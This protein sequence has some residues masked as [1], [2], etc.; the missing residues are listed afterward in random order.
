[1][2][3]ALTV[4]DWMTMVQLIYRLNCIEDFLQYQSKVLEIINIIV[5]FDA[6]VFH[7]ADQEQ[8][9]VSA[10]NTYGHNISEKDLNELKNGLSNN[11]FLKS[12]LLDPSGVVSRGP[13]LSQFSEL[14]LKLEN[15]HLIPKDEQHA[16]SVVLNYKDELLGYLILLRQDQEEQFNM[17]DKCVLE[18]LKNHIAL[19][20]YKLSNSYVDMN[21]LDNRIY[22]LERKLNKYGLSKRELEILA[23]IQSGKV[24]SEICEE[25]F[26]STSTF[27]KHLNHI[28][29]KMKVSNR[30]TLIKLINTEM[31]QA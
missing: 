13:D 27:K 4:A 17:R 22:V 10:G 6:G 9:G 24:D 31:Q 23:L 19:Q 30:V 16:F 15:E 25:L 5:P 18:N 12:L 29:G 1:M 28:Y 20:L 14:G 8:D 7:L 2:S 11:A 26:F 21:R 3:L